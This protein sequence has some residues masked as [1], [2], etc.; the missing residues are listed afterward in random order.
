MSTLFHYACHVLDLEE[1]ETF[2]CGLLGC[3]IGRK[4][5]TWI[6]INFFGHQ[7]SLHI[8]E[9]TA[10]SSTGVVDNTKVPMPH[11]GAILPSE[12]WQTLADRLTANGIDFIVKP[13]TR[14]K[15]KPG[16]QSTMFFCDP[17][18]NAIEL[19]GFADMKAV[20]DF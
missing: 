20:F 6:D 5:E 1:A 15:G 10:S 8:G 3:S 12:K 16:E 2:Y 14:F 9:A 13:T 4:S 19:K 18:G 11:F 17:S 7:L